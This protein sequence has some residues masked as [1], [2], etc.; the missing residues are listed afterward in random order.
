MT[1]MVGIGHMIQ[2][3]RPDKIADVT[4][5]YLG[6][7]FPGC[8][9]EVLLADYRISGL[10]PLLQSDHSTAGVLNDKATAGRAFASQRSTVEQLSGGGTRTMLPLSVWSDRLGVLVVDL[11]TEPDDQQLAELIRIADEVAVALVVADRSTD[12]YRLARRRQR[13]TMAAEMQWDLL[14][15]RSLGG[16]SFL[17]AGQLEPAYAV[18]GDHFD[19]SLAGDHLTITALNGYGDGLPATMLTM[20]AVTAMRNARRSGGNL[21]EQAELASET[22]FG[23]HGGKAH[24]ATLLLDVDLVSGV[25]TAIDAGSPLAYR[26]RHHATTPITLQQQLPL[27]MFPDSQYTVETF[28][29]EPADRLFIVSDGVHGAKPGGRTQYGQSGLLSAIR[30]TR[31]QPATEAVG[32]VMRGLHEYHAEHDLDDDAV[33]VCLD[34]L[35]PV[36]PGDTQ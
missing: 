15:G 35:G 17:L 16:S 34:W 12:R 1:D 14:P 8:R 23:V 33:I 7:R 13:M 4:A 18:C 36:P 20:L 6:S 28:T 9:V 22:V 27:G 10:W 31:L 32:S 26:V 29:L 24:V 21:V 19:W 2:R 5:S 30:A 3:A 25:V 11:K